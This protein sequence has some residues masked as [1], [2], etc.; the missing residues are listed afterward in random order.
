M[1][2]VVVDA[3]GKANWEDICLM[4]TEGNLNQSLYAAHHDRDYALRIDRNKPQN[5]RDPQEP[6]ER[7][8]DDKK[9]GNAQRTLSPANGSYTAEA[10]DSHT[11]NFTA[12]SAYSSVYWY[13]KTPSDTSAYGTTQE[14]DVGNGSTTTAD[15]TYTFP[16]G[17]S[18]DYQIMAYVYGGDNTVYEE[19]YTVS[20]SA[21]SSSTTTTSTSTTPSSSTTTTT[22]T[23]TTTPA[24]TVTTPSS[25]T[26]FDPT[27]GYAS[28]IVGLYWGAPDSDGGATVTDYEY[29]YRYRKGK[30]KNKKW[31][32]W[33]SWSSAGT[34]GFYLVY[35]LLSYVEYEFKMRAVNSEGAGAETGRVRR[36]VI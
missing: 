12:P 8:E 17:V 23:T 24:S 20:V 13:V 18:G 22:T 15:F 1:T 31:S 16:S 14:I 32:D 36:H 5:E 10:G 19:K 6:Y 9:S 35:N 26:S 11:A 2:D 7:P 27:Q 21:P 33:T 34:S 28:G 29:Q 4:F 30:G 3:N 25:P